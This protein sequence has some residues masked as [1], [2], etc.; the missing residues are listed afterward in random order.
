LSVNNPLL[1]KSNTIYTNDKI[2]FLV[3]NNILDMPL[4]YELEDKINTDNV[5]LNSKYTTYNMNSNATNI[6]NTAIEYD[7]LQFTK[8][9]EG[10]QDIFMY[11]LYYNQE[12]GLVLYK[13]ANIAPYPTMFAIYRLGYIFGNAYYPNYLKLGI[14]EFITKTEMQD[15]LEISTNVEEGKYPLTV[16]EHIGYNVKDN[17]KLKDRIKSD[18]K[19]LKD[20][21]VAFTFPINAD[22]TVNIIEGGFTKEL[23]DTFYIYIIQLQTAYTE[24]NIKDNST[25]ILFNFKY[26]ISQYIDYILQTGILFIPM[27]NPFEM[28]SIIT[29]PIYEKYNRYIKSLF[30]DDVNTPVTCNNE[31]EKWYTKLC[32]AIRNNNNNNA[33]DM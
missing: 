31:N 11:A 13:I 7:G 26:N 19:S 28:R 27:N 22:S 23:I 14:A 32:N 29:Q 20:N 25:S 4:Y 33:G 6:P 15:L 17:V 3:K 10:T 1:S 16:I 5:K 12:Y 18:T 2:D 21:I 24:Y 9:K 30:N 8:F